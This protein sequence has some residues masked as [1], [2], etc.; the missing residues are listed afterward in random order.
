[1]DLRKLAA[2]CRDAA[3]PA[4]APGKKPAF[5]LAETIAQYALPL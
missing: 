2:L 4:R 3:T 1:L 5:D